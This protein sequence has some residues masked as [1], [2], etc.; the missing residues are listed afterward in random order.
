MFVARRLLEGVLEEGRQGEGTPVFEQALDSGQRSQTEAGVA[1][2]QIGQ[3]GDDPKA[4]PPFL[5]PN[6][7]AREYLSELGGQGSVGL[8]GT[9]HRFSHPV[10]AVWMLANQRRESLS[11]D[12]GS[13]PIL[14]RDEEDSAA[15]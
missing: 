10:H 5:D 2:A 1:P 4:R 3:G 11:E 8:H 13:P 6:R 9:S 15:H 14:A 12:S 7:A